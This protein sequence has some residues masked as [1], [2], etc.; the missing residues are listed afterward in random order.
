M[1][2]ISRRDF[3]KIGGLALGSLAFTSFLP[4][5]TEFEDIEMVRVANLTESVYLEPSAKSQI[6]ATWHR[7]D[8]VHVY[9]Q[10]QT[11]T[12]HTS[13]VNPSWYRVWGGYMN[14]ARLQ[15]V[16]VTYNSPLQ[17]IPDTK[18]IGEVTV[19]F[20]QAYT[21]D[22]WN[23]WKTTYRLYFGTVHWLKGVEAGPDGQPWYQIID[24]ADSSIYYVPAVQVRPIPPEE[25][26]PISPDVPFEKKNI[27]VDLKTQTLTCTENGQVVLQTPVSTGWAG[28]S[29]D[30]PTTTPTGTYNIQDKMPSK[31]MGN[32]NLAA[33]VDDY[34]L[35]GVPWVGFFT[36]QGHAFHGTYWHDN[37]GV[38]MSH[39]CVNMRTEDAKWLFRW[40]RPSASFDQI[41]KRRLGTIGF[42]TQADISGE[43]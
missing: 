1:K 16:K 21:Y 43:Y 12:P 26:T 11:Q 42:G 32:A 34:V 13:Y 7:D 29:I 33:G 30:E 39:G 10:V 6:V 23:G 28:L 40:T 4:G 25:L 17:S 37:F 22:K 18:L 20:A 24:E 31:H 2:T 3:L 38:P 35:P 14:Q 27:K 19:P 36:T 9:A 41:D 15:K 8:L 5:I